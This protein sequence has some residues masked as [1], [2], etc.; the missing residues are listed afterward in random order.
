MRYS[1][2]NMTIGLLG[3]ERQHWESTAGSERTLYNSVTVCFGLVLLCS[4]A[5]SA[6]LMHLILSN[7]WLALPVSLV[8]S[9]IIASVLR[10]S[11]IILRRSLFDVE[12]FIEPQNDRGKPISPD[13]QTANTSTSDQRR[14]K[15]A[16]T[17]NPVFRHGP[18]L[19]RLKSYARHRWQSLTRFELPKGSDKVPGLKALI[20]VLIMAVVCLLVAF[21]LACLFHYQAIE[22]VN[23]AMRETYYARFREE[24]ARTLQARTKSLRI[25]IA[26]LEADLLQHAHTYRSD[27]LLQDKRREL[28]LAR[29]TLQQDEQE[30]QASFDLLSER[31]RARLEGSRFLVLSF[32]SVSGMPFFIPILFVIV[33]LVVLPHAILTWLKTWGGFVYSRASTTHYKQIIDSAYRETEAAGYARLASVYGYVPDEVSKQNLYWENPPY[34]TIPRRYYVPRHPMTREQFLQ[35]ISDPSEGKG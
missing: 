15:P 35:D 8:V 18:Y 6:R 21:P 22:D 3:L 20:R 25:R 24:G 14:P 31:Y 26:Q 16:S 19:T 23:A 10:F 1:L 7:V 2:E 9:F 30:I 11:L 5:A 13:G 32:R 29:T 33:L 34:N 4:L 28:A 12:A 17:P 27:G